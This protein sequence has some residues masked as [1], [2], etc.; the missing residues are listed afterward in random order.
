MGRINEEK[1]KRLVLEYKS[2]SESVI[3]QII[4]EIS[5]YI[6][7]FPIIIYN[8]PRDE[9]SE[10][11]IYFLERIENYIKG[12]SDKGYK[13][14]T[15]LTHVLINSYKNF[16]IQKRKTLKIIYE[17][18]IDSI[19]LLYVIHDEKSQENDI[20]VDK[21]MEFFN[22]LDEFSKLIIKTLIFELSPDD[23]F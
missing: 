15:Y 9:A 10:F 21:A 18:E 1:V 20:L 19:N 22:S 4:K 12:F 16:L 6:Y 3:N 13:F 14:S 7:N 11:Y 17:S 8:R 23:L 2:G 5:L